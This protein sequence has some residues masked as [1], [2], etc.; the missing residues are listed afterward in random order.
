MKNIS[1][2]GI[3]RKYAATR[4]LTHLQNMPVSTGLSGK[5]RNYFH[6]AGKIKILAFIHIKRNNNTTYNP[7]DL[8]SKLTADV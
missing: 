8:L 5:K 6:E 3:I 2:A 1:N 4:Y 7:K